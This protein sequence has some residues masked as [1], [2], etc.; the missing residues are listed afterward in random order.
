MARD[1]AAAARFADRF[2]NDGPVAE[3]ARSIAGDYGS[4]PLD[5]TSAKLLE[6]LARL[7]RPN[8]V[9]EV[10]TGTGVSTLSLLAGMPPS[11]ILTSIDTNHSR[12]SVTSEL[13]AAA[14]IKPHR[15]R[16]IT[17]RAEGVLARL[18]AGGYECVFLDTDPACYD[19]LIPLAVD[20]LAPGG[21]LIV[22]DVLMGGAVADPTNRTPKVNVLRSVLNDVAARD[23]LQRLVLPV[24][25]GLLVLLKDA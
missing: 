9:V 11:G 23:S 13:A 17:G 24:D 10:G 15:L 6:V 21:M 18:A 20:R 1:R 4:T 5:H 14:G 3:A 22:N 25:A 8:A 2:N 16:L 12:Q 19:R 7:S